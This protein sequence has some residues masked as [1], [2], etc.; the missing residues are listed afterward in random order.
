MLSSR[1]RGQEHRGGGG[2]GGDLHLSRAWAWRGRGAGQRVIGAFGMTSRVLV[3]EDDADIALS[4]RTVLTRS[5]FDVTGA[6]DGREGLA[7]SMPAA[8]TWWCWTSGSRLLTAGRS[9]S[10]SVT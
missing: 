5:G 9:W 8:R 2:Y 7:I 4:I 3:I 10:G 6:A 1:H